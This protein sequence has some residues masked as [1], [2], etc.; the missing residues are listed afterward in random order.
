LE[1]VLEKI[2]NQPYET[3][4]DVPAGEISEADAYESYGETNKEEKEGYERLGE[5]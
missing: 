5:T 2:K 3:G 4:Y 1:A